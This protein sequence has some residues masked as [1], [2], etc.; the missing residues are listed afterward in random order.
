MQAKGLSVR[1]C[2]LQLGGGDRSRMLRYQNKYRSLVRNRRNLVEETM[3][4]LER[5]GVAY[6]NP[7]GD[8]GQE[9]TEQTQAGDRR[10]AQALLTEFAEETG[11]NLIDLINGMNALLARPAPEDGTRWRRRAEAAEEQA[12]RYLA[13][14]QTLSLALRDY[15]T[16]RDP[17]RLPELAALIDEPD[18]HLN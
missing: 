8:D 14:L 17:K 13:K 6:L 18:I 4:T 12:S 16:T 2:A 3:R 1:A 11:V 9:E 5:E 10:W 7:Y 15:L